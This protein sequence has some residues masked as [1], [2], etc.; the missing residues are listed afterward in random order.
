[1]PRVD[2][3]ANFERRRIRDPNLFAEFKSKDIGRKG[4]SYIVLGRLKGTNKWVTQSLRIHKMESPKMK[5]KLRKN[6]RD[7]IRRAKIR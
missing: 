6:A 7:M 4:F 3:T 1:M 2:Y 5:A